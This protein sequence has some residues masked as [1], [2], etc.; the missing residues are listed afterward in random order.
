MV[1]GEGSRVSLCALLVLL[2]VLLPSCVLAYGEDVSSPYIPFP[3][4]TWYD[5]AMMTLI[6]MVRIGKKTTYI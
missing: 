5:R 1:V 6:N 4:P 2:L 3:I